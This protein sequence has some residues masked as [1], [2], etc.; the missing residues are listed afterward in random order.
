MAKAL[1][2]MTRSTI[3]SWVRRLPYGARRA[4]IQ[5]LAEG[6]R[7]NGFGLAQFAKASGISSVMAHG[8]SGLV[9]ASALDEFIIPNY[10]VSGT[11]AQ[12]TVDFIRTALPKGGTYLDIGA[13]IGL[14]TI[15]VAQNPNVHCIAF[16]PD[17]TNFHHLSENVRR[18][19]S[20]GNVE[21][22]QNA[23]MEKAGTLQLG[24]SD[25]GNAGDHAIVR[26]RTNR[27]TVEVQGVALDDA[28]PDISAPLAIKIDTQGA[29]PFVLAGG[30][31]TFGKAAAIVLEFWPYGMARMG[32]D[33]S[34][35]FELV[36]QFPAVTVTKGDSNIS[37][38]FSSGD[39]LPVLRRYLSEAAPFDGRSWDLYLSRTHQLVP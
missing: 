27:K 22:R 3:R 24:L 8:T 11:W 9:Q 15:Q 39:A 17:P 14:T 26:Q 2:E 29:E 16:E 7:D 31:R 28:L 18:N 33:P 34:E 1:K 20:H 5:G 10:G 12:E 6:M 30:K 13:N 36:K 25:E 23:V 4:L 35:I 19:C 38:H 37:E 21:L 32:S